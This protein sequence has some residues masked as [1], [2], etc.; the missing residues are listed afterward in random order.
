MNYGIAFAPLVPSIVLWIALAA[1]V[2]IAALLLLGRARGAM[3]R[4]AALALIA[5]ALANPSFTREDRE[6]LTSV[7]AVVVD[8][9]PSQNFGSRT[10]ETARAHE[11]LVD[12][13]KKISGLE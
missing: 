13:L 7:A 6:P 8:K 10:N 12:S 4:L 1:I 11:A 9:S 5:L 2:V 3:V